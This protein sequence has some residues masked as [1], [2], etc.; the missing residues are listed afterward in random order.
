ML[1]WISSKGVVAMEALP[2]GFIVALQA[3]HDSCLGNLTL[4]GQSKRPSLA[5]LFILFW[6]ICPSLA[7]HL[8]E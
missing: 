3:K 2:K 5:S 4:V 6:P 8:T 1:G 7:C